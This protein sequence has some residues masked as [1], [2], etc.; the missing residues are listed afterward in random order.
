[1]NSLV[2]K[3]TQ[4][5]HLPLAVGGNICTLEDARDRFNWGADKIVINSLLDSDIDMG[6][7]GNN[8]NITSSNNLRNINIFIKKIS[9]N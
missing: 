3:I 4:N 9:E 6:A 7:L 8:I 5:C 1:M 2:T